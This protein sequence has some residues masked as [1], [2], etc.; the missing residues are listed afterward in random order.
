[1]RILAVDPGTTES[2]FCWLNNDGPCAERG[3][4]PNEELLVRLRE[5]DTPGAVLAVEQVG[6]YGMPVGAEVFTTVLW[7]GRFIEAWGGDFLLVPRRDVKLHLCGQ[8]RAKD[9]NIRQAILDR[10]G[11]KVRAVGCKAQ[12]GPL[13]GIKSHLW[14]ALAIALTVQDGAAT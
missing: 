8:A 5:Y 3:I 7:A 1:V 14:S 9:G 10:F 6:S 2:A 12:P 11:G 13:Y 4:V